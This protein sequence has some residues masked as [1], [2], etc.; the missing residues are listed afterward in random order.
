MTEYISLGIAALGFFA[1]VYY[2]NRSVKEKDIGEAVERAKESA[3]MS[4]KLNG[5]SA[6]VRSVGKTMDKIEEKMADQS[7]RLSKVEE[8]TKSAH[9]RIDG[10]EKVMR[11]EIE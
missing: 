6:D 3:K 10:I 11:K 7:T 2:S 1:S 4:E 5:I 9:R 8:A